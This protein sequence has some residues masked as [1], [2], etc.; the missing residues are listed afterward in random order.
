LRSW[1]PQR[2]DALERV[3]GKHFAWLTEKH[4][5][6][7]QRAAG[8]F[9]GN[10][11]SLD[12]RLRDSFLAW[13]NCGFEVGP[14][15]RAIDRFASEHGA[16]L[17]AVER[18]ALEQIRLAR[19]CL[20]VVADVNEGVGFHATDLFTGES[21]FVHERRGSQQLEEGRAVLGWL[22][23]SAHCHE[24]G[25]PACIVPSAQVDAVNASFAQEVERQRQVDPGAA[26]A[27]LLWRA[28]PVAHRTLLALGREFEERIT[29][30]VGRGLATTRAVY[31]VHDPA[32]VRKRLDG[33][34]EIVRTGEDHWQWQGAAHSPSDGR[35]SS[36]AIDLERVRLTL[37]A[38]GM[39]HLLA[40]K[41]LV[42]ARLGD[43]VAHR[44]DEVDDAAKRPAAPATSAALASADDD[45]ALDLH[46][47]HRALDDAMLRW[48]ARRAQPPGRAERRRA[49]AR[50]DGEQAL[51]LAR[52]HRH[53]MPP[54]AHETMYD[55]V[56]GM[57]QAVAR[58]AARLHTAA[59]DAVPFPAPG[60]L[61]DQPEVKELL[62]AH[63]RDRF[64]DGWSPGDAEFDA[65]LLGAH[66]YYSLCHEL[67]YRKT[68]WVDEALA[69]ML[70]ETELDIRGGCL[71]LPFPALALA[72]TDR[73]TLDLAEQCL[74]HVPDCRLQGEPIEIL[75]VY[76]VR[77]PEERP[78]GAFGLHMCFLFEAGDGEWPYLL[79]RDLNVLA[80]ADLEA[81]LAS[82]APDVDLESLDPVFFGPE[83]EKLVHLTLN[84]V[85]YATSA[86][87]EP[88]VL[89]PDVGSGVPGRRP[90]RRRERS[91][92]SQEPVF[93]MPGKIDIA[94][95]R[96]LRALAE[97]EPG[98]ELRA[99]FMVR[100][101]WRR[102]NPGWSDQ[103]LRWI[104]P[105]WK[106]PDL[107]TIIE[108]DY[109]LRP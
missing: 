16:A 64:R 23:R 58:C 49:G 66:V 77:L 61:G 1:E 11:P 54:L 103:R 18:E 85:L 95:V 98:R 57:R 109:R 24:L 83:L 48:E 7:L 25:P 4:A 108:R 107:A 71:Q 56:P 74:A 60:A 102:A 17:P 40:A 34:S 38:H 12:D 90:R 8:V 79:T 96:Q 62:Q 81:I 73:G 14:G 26:P 97:T 63:M 19:P 27:A 89:Q 28:L 99:R 21:L 10:E 101:H 53:R 55:L 78:D 29:A 65:D 30:T 80:E 59:G 6:W 91:A 42:E 9:R 68:F 13:L 70:A 20:L 72:W 67:A 106:G 82:R 36:V 69:W 33:T 37:I 41:K 44:L 31:R 84:A 47:F 75:T 2:G 88:I 32:L 52:R 104:E 15:V 105:Y 45:L 86:H 76:V 50:G 22:V 92:R 94:R 51:E 39:V 43:A 35:T 5:E 87:L 100:G 93:W 3:C 46:E